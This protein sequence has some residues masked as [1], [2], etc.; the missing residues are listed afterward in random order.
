[1]LRGTFASYGDQPAKAAVGNGK[2]SLEGLCAS[3]Y[4]TREKTFSEAGDVASSGSDGNMITLRVD[5]EP[6]NTSV[7]GLVKAFRF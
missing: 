7:H 4:L 3:S 1:M 6:L 2:I 5:W